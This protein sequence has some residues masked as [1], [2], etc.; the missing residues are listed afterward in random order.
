MRMPTTSFTAATT[1]NMASSE[2]F[3]NDGLFGWMGMY[4]DMLGMEEGKVPK[5]GFLASDPDVDDTTPTN[6]AEAAAS[7]QNAVDNMTNIGMQERERRDKAGDVAVLVTV[8]YAIV[9]SLFLDDGSL[10]GGHLVR[11]AIVVPLFL[12]M[13]YKK[14]AETGL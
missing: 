5:F 6:D 3:Q 7:R 1:L 8:A 11:F 2:E 9:S 4:L 14:S 12:A 13:G 10:F